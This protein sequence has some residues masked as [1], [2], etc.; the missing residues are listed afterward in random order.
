MYLHGTEKDTGRSYTLTDAETLLNDYFR[1]VERILQA[2]QVSFD[3]PRRGRDVAADPVFLKVML[4]VGLSTPTSSL[5]K[6]RDRSEAAER[7]LAI[8]SMMAKL[9]SSLIA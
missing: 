9:M 3:S 1:K 5:A 8:C 7:L 2:H 6:V 4:R